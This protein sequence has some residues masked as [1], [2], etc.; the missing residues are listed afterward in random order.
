MESLLTDGEKLW[1]ILGIMLGMSMA[2][3]VAWIIQIYQYKK[4]NK[5]SIVEAIIATD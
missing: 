2:V 5:C 4:K 3:I 1:F